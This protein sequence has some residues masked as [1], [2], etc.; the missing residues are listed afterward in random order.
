MTTDYKSTV[1]LPGANSRCAEASPAQA[2]YRPLGE[3]IDLYRRQREISA[4]REKFILHDGPPYANGNLHIGHALNKIL[5]DVINRSQ[6]MIGKDANYV[7]GWDCHG[8]PIEWKIEEKYRSEGR[9]KDEV[10]IVEFRQECREFADHWI[11]VQR[12]EFERLGVIGD[13]ENPYTTMNFAHEAQIARELMKFV[14]N[15]LL[16]QGSKPVMWSVVEKTALAEAEVEYHDHE[17]DTIWCKFGVAGEA[18][19]ELSGADYLDNDA[20]DHSWQQGHLLLV[21]AYGMYEVNAASDE[22]WAA[23]GDRLILADSLADE[24]CKLSARIDD[25][26]RVGDVSAKKASPKLAALTLWRA[27]CR[28]SCRCWMAI[29]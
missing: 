19:E 29:M 23:A 22:N 1:F 24:V 4:G 20:M 14:D 25:W 27:G 26:A 7:P 16:Y 28:L 10:P 2:R 9:D 15:G 11:N 17:S 21:G 12:E 13:W 8:L 18:A 3:D 5:K 6:Q